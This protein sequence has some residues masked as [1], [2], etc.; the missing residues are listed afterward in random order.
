VVSKIEYSAMVSYNFLENKL[1]MV[2]SACA[3]VFKSYYLFFVTIFLWSCSFFKK[4]C[5]KIDS[6]A[7]GMQ[8]LAAI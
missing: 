4:I 1:R 8:V 7:T 6:K 3:I 2:F 5:F